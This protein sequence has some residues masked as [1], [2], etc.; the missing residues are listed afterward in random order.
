MAAQKARFSDKECMD[1]LDGLVNLLK[2]Q[3]LDIEQKTRQIAGDVQEARKAKDLILKISHEIEKMST[4]TRTACE[5]ARNEID[6]LSGEVKKSHEEIRHLRKNHG[7]PVSAISSD[8]ESGTAEKSLSGDTNPMI[9]EDITDAR[10]GLQS[11]R[12]FHTA[13]DETR[14]KQENLQQEMDTLES[15]TKP[16]VSRL[17]IQN[18]KLDAIG[19]ELQ[20]ERD[21]VSILHRRINIMMVSALIAMAGFIGLVMIL[22][23]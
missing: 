8:H 9:T 11:V 6:V 7:D 3:S 12:K 13:G 21:R 16:L 2:K 14:K 23:L 17:E 5:K 10:V 20:D 4:E 18:R 15:L 22:R 1:Q 19:K